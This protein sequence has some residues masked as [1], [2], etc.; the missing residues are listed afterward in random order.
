MKFRIF[1][2]D[3]ILDFSILFVIALGLLVNNYN[4]VYLLLFSSLHE[5]GHIFI[6][7]IFR[8]KPSCIKVSFYGIGLKHFD[9]LSFKQDLL[10]LSAGILVNLFFAVVGIKRKINLD[11]AL[12]NFLP[13]Y[14][15]DGGRLLKLVLDTLFVE[16]SYYV[17]LIFSFIV[18]VVLAVFSVTQKNYNLLLIVFYILSF[19]IKEVKYD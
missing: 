19:W 12:V 3:F 11:L 18:I 6:L 15:L 14:P 2:I 10:F 17:Y 1:D 5:L 4:V 7:L 16:W 9:D 13:M 8:K